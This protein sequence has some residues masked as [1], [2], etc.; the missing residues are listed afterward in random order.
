M[1]RSAGWSYTPP[2]LPFS[3]APCGLAM[4]SSYDDRSPLIAVAASAL[5]NN[6][7]AATR[8]VA[9]LLVIL[10]ERDSGAAIGSDDDGALM[11]S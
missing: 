10:L 9:M 8:A 1:C 7:D 4:A 3:I 2:E 5:A 11:A 6:S